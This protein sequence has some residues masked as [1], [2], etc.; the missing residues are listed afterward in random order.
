MWC[1]LNINKPGVFK[2]TLLLYTAT[3]DDH[4]IHELAKEIESVN[5]TVEWE[6]ETPK[7]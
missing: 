7:K 1:D 6:N 4:P 5:I 2:M 3:D